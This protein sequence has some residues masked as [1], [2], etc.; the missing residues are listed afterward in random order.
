MHY[1]A[2]GFVNIPEV[3][4]D[5]ERDIEIRKK[6]EKLEDRKRRGKGDM[7]TDFKIEKYSLIQTAFG[8]SVDDAVLDIMYPYWKGMEDPRYL[9][10]YGWTEEYRKMYEE[11]ADDLI[12][13]PN[14]SIECC[15]VTHSM[16]CSLSRMGRCMKQAT[17]Q[18]AA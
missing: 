8:R 12:L 9:E 13:I 11:G 18:A 3:Q 6:L 1:F 4:E 14:G 16:A 17:A 15:R 5:K 7:M 2:L 10:F